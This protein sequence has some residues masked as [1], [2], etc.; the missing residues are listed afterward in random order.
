MGGVCGQH[1]HLRR[2]DI[3][4]RREKWHARHDDTNEFDQLAKIFR[5][6]VSSAHALNGSRSSFQIELQLS[7][8]TIEAVGQL[9]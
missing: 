6:C 4:A 3:V 2:R 5:R 9:I 7:E 8:V 1:G